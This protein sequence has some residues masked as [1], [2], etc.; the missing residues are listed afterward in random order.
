MVHCISS[1]E[2]D[3]GEVCGGSQDMDWS[4][5]NSVNAGYKPEYEMSRGHMH[6]SRKPETPTHMAF[7]ESSTVV[8]GMQLI[9]ESMKTQDS[10]VSSRHFDRNIKRKH[11]DTLVIM[12]TRMHSALQ[13]DEGN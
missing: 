11:G 6:I 2:P 10:I 7:V 1:S 4:R 9:A 13:D 3:S 8:S 12:E 5:N